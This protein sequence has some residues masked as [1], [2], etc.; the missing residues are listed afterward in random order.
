MGQFASGADMLSLFDA[1]QINIARFGSRP[2]TACIALAIPVPVALR[3]TPS[4]NL[5]LAV[6]A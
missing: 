6:F 1:K 3:R 5:R 4:A 2:G